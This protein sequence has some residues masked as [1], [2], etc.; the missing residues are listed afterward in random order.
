MKQLQ[1]LITLLAAI[2]FSNV[3]AQGKEY[4]CQLLD[5]DNYG[6][7]FYLKGSDGTVLKSDKNGVIKVSKSQMDKFAN[8]TFTLHFSNTMAYLLYRN[9]VYFQNGQNIS[10]PHYDYDNIKLSQLLIASSKTY[11]VRRKENRLEDKDIAKDKH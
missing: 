7:D 4:S 5:P 8:E 2:S 10:D 3:A 9:H 1:L 11:Y 6:V